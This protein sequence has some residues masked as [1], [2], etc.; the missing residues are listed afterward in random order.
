[1]ASDPELD[2]GPNPYAS[3]DFHDPGRPERPS[4]VAWI[5]AGFAVGT[6]LGA[7][8]HFMRTGRMWSDLSGSLWLFGGGFSGAVA[9]RI[10]A[11][12]LTA[13]YAYKVT[14]S[15]RAELLDELDERRKRRPAP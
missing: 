9:G 2:S 15:R 12:F 1:M 5:A 3:P 10:V 14:A 11:Q 8:A 6:A 13:R 7:A 4:Q